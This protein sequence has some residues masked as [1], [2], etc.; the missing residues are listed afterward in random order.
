VAN[1]VQGITSVVCGSLA[2]VSEAYDLVIVNILARVIVEMVGEGLASRIRP[3]GLLIAAGIT[4]EQEPEVATALQHGG[5]TLILAERQQRDD[6]VCLV[7]GR[8]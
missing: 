1:G 2:E 7:A 8:N 6:W 3:G 4:V 5:L